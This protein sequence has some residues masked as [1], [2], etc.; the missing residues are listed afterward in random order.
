MVFR[1]SGLSQTQFLIQVQDVS[2]APQDNPGV[3][4]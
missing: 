3:L 2:L 4:Y 1:L